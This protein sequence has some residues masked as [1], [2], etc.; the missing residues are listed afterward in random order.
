M[1]EL[2]GH[3]GAAVEDRLVHVVLLVMVAVHIIPVLI[4][5]G[6]KAV[7]IGDA[8]LAEPGEVLAAHQGCGGNEGFLT[9]KL[10]NGGLRNAIELLIA[11]DDRLRHILIA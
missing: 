5:A 7:D 10:G 3:C 6:H 4:V 9:V 8:V 1:S 11:V 2:R